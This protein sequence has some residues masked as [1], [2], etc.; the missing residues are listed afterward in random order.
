MNPI[1]PVPALCRLAPVL[2]LVLGAGCASAGP[3]PAASPSSAATPEPDAPDE[4]AQEASATKEQQDALFAKALEL[5]K[6]GSAKQALDATA[7]ALEIA[8]AR[9]DALGQVN[10]MNLNAAIYRKLNEPQQML[11]WYLKASPILENLTGGGLEMAAHFHKIGVVQIELGENRGAVEHLGLAVSVR[12]MLLGLEHPDTISSMNTMAAGW[13]RLEDYDKAVAGFEHAA[14][15]LGKNAPESP[16]TVATYENL[17]NAKIKQGNPSEALPWL[18]KA[19]EIKQRNLHEGHVAIGFTIHYIG[20]AHENLGEHAKALEWY[21]RANA[22]IVK[23][24]GADHPHSVHG[25]TR[26]TEL[27]K[28][29]QSKQ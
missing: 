17:G 5:H 25:M 11:A 8:E 13:F 14:E 27:E 1:F 10:A 3:P 7:G 24:M 2:G 29:M 26:I 28:A 22:L 18:H 12:M 9:G 20:E 19:L 15:V 23:A 6:A 16:D 4:P 21:R